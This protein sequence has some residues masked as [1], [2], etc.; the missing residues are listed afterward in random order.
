MVDISST[1]M[2]KQWKNI[3]LNL[4]CSTCWN[5]IDTLDSKVD[6]LGSKNL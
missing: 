5:T 3:L 2:Q 4:S 1:Y 6:L